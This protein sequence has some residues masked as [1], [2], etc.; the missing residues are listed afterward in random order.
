MWWPRAPKQCVFIEDKAAQLQTDSISA[1]FDVLELTIANQWQRDHSLHIA[2]K[3]KHTSFKLQLDTTDPPLFGEDTGDVFTSDG[4]HACILSL[5][6]FRHHLLTM[7]TTDL[8][9]P[10]KCLIEL[11]TFPT[12]FIYLY[13]FAVIMPSIFFFAVLLLASRLCISPTVKS[14]QP[15]EKKRAHG[16]HQTDTHT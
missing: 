3:N 5:N 11:R 8:S 7:I 16:R 10:H 12:P 13:I 6:V 4:L 15:T 1:P 2:W 14:S 9:L